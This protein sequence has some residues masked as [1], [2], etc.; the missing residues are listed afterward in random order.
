VVKRILFALVGVLLALAIGLVLQS[1]LFTSD[2]PSPEPLHTADEAAAAQS[3]VPAAS[4][5][6]PPSQPVVT[7]VITVSGRV[8]IF[9]TSEGRWRPVTLGQQL[10]EDA[11]LRTREGQVALTI[12]ENI[13]ASVSA[14]S[15]F[16]LGELSNQLSRVRLE[17]GH[18]LAQV[19][20]GKGSELLVQVLGSTAEARATDAEFAVLRGDGGQ[21]TVAATRGNVKLAA[22]GSEVVIDSGEQ[23]VVAVGE[24]PDAPIKIPGELLVKLSRG[25]ARKLTHRNVMIEGETSPGAV[26]T[27]NG[28]PAATRQGRFALS[29]PLR[30]GNNEVTVVSRDILNRQTEHRVRGILVDSEPPELNGHVNW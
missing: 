5:A 15:Q 27:I 1:R 11:V 29:I 18:V 8:E 28:L 16:R 9:I 21:V 4:S 24:T 13:R 22:A 26:V 20:G 6:R 3:D 30:E 23:S 17:G 25:L 14:N 7:R 2:V 12:G 19:E 10:S